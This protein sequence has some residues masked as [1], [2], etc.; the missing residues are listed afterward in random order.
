MS[1]RIPGSSRLYMDS[2]C[3]TLS[4]SKATRDNPYRVYDMYGDKDNSFLI[5][6]KEKRAVHTSFII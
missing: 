2:M 3:L 4:S 1:K 6:L 5:T